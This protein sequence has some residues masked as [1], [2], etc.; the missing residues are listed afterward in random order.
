MN[1]FLRQ[2]TCAACVLL[3]N[4]VGYAQQ[5]PAAQQG[6]P[7]PVIGHCH[8]RS[9]PAAMAMGGHVTFCPHT[10]SCTRGTRSQKVRRG[11]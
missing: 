1:P 2:L 3:A 4:A 8:S 7:S 5:K 6:H 9:L 11:G 10:S